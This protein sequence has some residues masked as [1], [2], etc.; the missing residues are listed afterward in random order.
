[1][2]SQRSFFTGPKCRF[3]YCWICFA[4]YAEILRHGNTAH[5]NDCRYHSKNLREPAAQP[6][7]V[8]NVAPIGRLTGSAASGNRLNAVPAA[9]HPERHTVA[10]GPAAR[11]IFARGVAPVERST[12]TAISG[13][14][15]NAKPAAPHPERHTVAQGPAAQPIIAAEAAPVERL[16]GPAITRNRDHAEQAIHTQDTVRRAAVERLLETQQAPR[17]R[18]RLIFPSLW[19]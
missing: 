9:P 8:A 1:M 3:Q 5:R 14:R 16:T 11:P 6:I 18:G 7:P 17:A 2:C 19:S 4:D 13:N 12:V 15:L 10:Q